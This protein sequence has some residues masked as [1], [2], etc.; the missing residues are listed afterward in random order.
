M[1][2]VNHFIAPQEEAHRQRHQQEHR[3]A[4]QKLRFQPALQPEDG[5]VDLARLLD[6]GHLV[7]QLPGARRHPVEQNTHNHQRQHVAAQHAVK[8]QVEQIKR[9]RLVEYR[10]V[11]RFGRRDEIPRAHEAYHRPGVDGRGGDQVTQQQ[12]DQRREAGVQLVVAQAGIGEFHC[13]RVGHPQH[14]E[15]HQGRQ[16]HRRHA[17]IQHAHPGAELPQFLPPCNLDGV[18]GYRSGAEEQ[19]QYECDQRNAPPLGGAPRAPAVNLIGHAIKRST[20]H[21]PK[22][23][24]QIGRCL[25]DLRRMF[26][27]V[28]SLAASAL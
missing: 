16:G 23:L 3:R 24:A 22:R 9:K 8:R 26:A 12:Q 21:I 7:A 25:T 20:A 28:R 11:P 14:C 18:R 4:A 17:V 5:W 19:Y 13:A 15:R 27:P 1:L 6:V 10:V 2:V